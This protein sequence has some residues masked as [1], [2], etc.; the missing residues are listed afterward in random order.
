MTGDL[1]VIQDADL[2]Y[3]PEEFPELIQLICEGRADV[4]YGSRFLGRHRVFLFT[5]YAGNRLLTLV[6]NVLYNTMLTDM[7]TCY[8]VMRTEVLRSMTLR[9]RRI[10]H[11]AGA[12]REDLQAA[13]P[14][15]RGSDHLRRPRLRGREE[16]HVARRRRRA[17]GAAEVPIH[18]VTAFHRLL[19]YARPYRGRFVAALVAMLVYAVASATLALLIKPLTDKVLPQRV[20]AFFWGSRSIS[21]RGASPSSS[22]ISSRA[23][24]RTSPRI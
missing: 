4:V 7:E 5:H 11:R 15:L 21:R 23:S 2:E 8:K 14:R 13:L 19:G 3:S 12:D 17:L 24:A 1:V 18:R 20:D 6:T 10:R 22:S 9:V 16:D